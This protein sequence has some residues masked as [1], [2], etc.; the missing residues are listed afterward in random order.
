MTDPTDDEEEI[1]KIEIPEH[2]YAALL[3][4]ESM[5]KSLCVRGCGVTDNCVK[6]IANALKTNRTLTN[7]NLWDN[8]ITREGAE[9]LAESLSVGKN[10]VGNDG[11]AAFAK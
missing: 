9:A 2:L 1:Y 6:A 7:L 10:M 8:R 11:A 3:G 4:E 5:L